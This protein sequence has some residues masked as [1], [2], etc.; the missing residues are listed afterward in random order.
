MGKTVA[1]W[2]PF[3]EVE[4]RGR[5]NKRPYNLPQHNNELEWSFQKNIHTMKQNYDLN[6]KKKIKKHQ[7]K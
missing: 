2:I 7:T 3:N 5:L 6:L 1:R 4:C